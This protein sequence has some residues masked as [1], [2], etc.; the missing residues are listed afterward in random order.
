M[1]GPICFTFSIPMFTKET[2]SDLAFSQFIFTVTVNYIYLLYQ[3][4]IDNAYSSMYSFL[5]REDCFNQ[6][7]FSSLSY[8]KMEVH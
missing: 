5:C 3:L 1:N 8:L 6:L 7:M 2:I 4:R